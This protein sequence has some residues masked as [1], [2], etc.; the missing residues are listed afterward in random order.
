M[1]LTAH[2]RREASTK[3]N[4]SSLSHT[5]NG[6]R[7]RKGPASRRWQSEVLTDSVYQSRF[8]DVFSSIWLK[9]RW[10]VFRFKGGEAILDSR[11]AQSLTLPTPESFLLTQCVLSGKLSHCSIC[12]CHPSTLKNGRG[13]R[14]APSEGKDTSIFSWLMT[15]SISI[16]IFETYIWIAAF[17]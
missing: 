2:E 9:G 16:I 8:V 12:G 7:G 10:A 3:I 15:S 6:R 14:R 4:K 13:L 5:L 11:L 1:L 17:V